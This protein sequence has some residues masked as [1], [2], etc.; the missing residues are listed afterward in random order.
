MPGRRR[1]SPNGAAVLA[2]IA[3]SVGLNGRSQRRPNSASGRTLTAIAGKAD[4]SCTPCWP[5]RL[6]PLLH[7]RSAQACRQATVPT[8]AHAVFIRCQLRGCHRLL[9][10][11][12]G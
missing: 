10:L 1:Y 3:S 9:L 8:V 11:G 5:L 12:S 6:P 2:A 7:H 4:V